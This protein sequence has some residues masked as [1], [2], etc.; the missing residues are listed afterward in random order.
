MINHIVMAVTDETFNRAIL[1]QQY[2]GGYNGSKMDWSP[3]Q[4]MRFM[5]YETFY[6]TEEKP[7]PISTSYNNTYHG[8]SER[9]P[10]SFSAYVLMMF[11][12]LLAIVLP[13]M[14]FCK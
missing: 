13:I 2:G 11:F 12:I 4:R 1:Q 8:P 6:P 14:I 3:E 9:E 7:E 10:M 5:A